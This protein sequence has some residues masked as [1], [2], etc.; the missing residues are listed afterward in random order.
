MARPTKKRP[1]NKRLSAYLLMN[2]K[3]YRLTKDKKVIDLEVIAKLAA[4][5]ATDGEI[6]TIIGCSP[7]WLRK[8]IEINPAFAMAM[9]QGQTD[10]RTSLR[11]AQLQ[12]AMSGSPAM[13]IWLGKQYLGQSDKQETTN[14]TEISIT[15]QRAMDELR[16]IPKHRLLDAQRALEGG[17]TVV[18]E[19]AMAQE[20]ETPHPPATV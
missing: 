15:V 12:L 6:A 11:R 18:E 19:N 1:E 3:N 2:E 5:N 17:Y 20:A 16:D 13:L 9:E 4:I 7:E 14:K 10:F 8:Q